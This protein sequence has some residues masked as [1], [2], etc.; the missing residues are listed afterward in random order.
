MWLWIGYES[1]L[2]D[3]WMWMDDTCSCN[4]SWRW[5][6]IKNTK[7]YF[8]SVHEV[9]ECARKGFPPQNLIN[10]I[11][12]LSLLMKTTKPLDKMVDRD[13]VINFNFC[14]NHA[15][16]I[17]KT[18]SMENFQFDCVQVPKSLIC[19]VFLNM[20]QTIMFHQYSF[21]FHLISNIFQPN[22]FVKSGVCLLCNCW[23]TQV[24]S[25]DIFLE[26]KL[27]WLY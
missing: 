13:A 15:I 7:G 3:G 21:V 6:H 11:L 4:C 14:G 17:S 27:E 25:Y 12:H 9:V 20:I 1:R 26:W 18:F 19:L 22:I 5:N 8:H 16:E 10:S 2:E 23:N 24:W